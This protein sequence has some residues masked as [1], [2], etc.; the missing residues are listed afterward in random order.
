[1][2]NK[3]LRFMSKYRVVWHLIHIIPILITGSAALLYP[4]WWING[5]LDGDNLTDEI[6][7]KVGVGIA[8]YGGTIG[9][10][11]WYFRNK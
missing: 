10:A 3:F 5:V 6:Y 2:I 11:I 8:A 4:I 9:H 1:M 7:L